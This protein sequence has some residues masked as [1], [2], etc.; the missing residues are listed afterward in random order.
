MRTPEN[1]CLCNQI[2]RPTR[3]EIVRQRK[4]NSQI[5]KYKI[6]VLSVHCLSA[7]QDFSIRNKSHCHLLSSSHVENIIFLILYEI[8]KKKK[9]VKWILKIKCYDGWLLI[10]VI[11]N[12]IR[13]K[14]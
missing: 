6:K 2:D 10:G 7:K 9:S 14:E 4:G 3:R 1:H 13:D 8:L 12:V 11:F 5:Y